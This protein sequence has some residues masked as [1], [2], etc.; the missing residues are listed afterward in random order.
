[1]EHKWNAG[2][3]QRTLGLP[4]PT[5]TLTQKASVDSLKRK[6]QGSGNW[7]WSGEG[8]SALL[9]CPLAW[10]QMER[11]KPSETPE[12]LTPTPTPT[13]K[14]RPSVEDKSSSRRA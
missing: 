9:H 3:R 10:F 11:S 7:W 12:C 13:G 5:G 8:Q 1:M 14:I 4:S 6:R 2:G